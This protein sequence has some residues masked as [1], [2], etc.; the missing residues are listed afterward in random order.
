MKKVN[1]DISTETILSWKDGDTKAFGRIVLMYMKTAYYAALGYVGNVEDA[2]DLSQEAFVATFKARRRF[3]VTKPFFPWFYTILRNICL[4]FIKR[5]QSL[6]VTSEVLEYIANG[7]ENPESYVSNSEK[8]NIIWEA[9]FKLS[10]DHREVVILK[11]LSGFSYKEIARMLNLPEGTVMSRLYY[12]R[13]RLY[14]LLKGF[15]F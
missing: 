10:P 15:D 2:K 8:A 12:A 6:K 7:N 11:D 13:N 9:L 3:D 5:H 1:G 14:E 4:N